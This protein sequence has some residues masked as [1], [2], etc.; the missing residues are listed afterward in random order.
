M[1]PVSRVEG[2]N[3]YR[4]MAA[5]IAKIERQFILNERGVKS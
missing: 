4:Q 2:T 3:D 5:D 1:C